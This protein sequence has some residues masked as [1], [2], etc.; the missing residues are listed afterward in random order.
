M[1]R[2]TVVAKRRFYYGGRDV[3][4]GPVEMH[5]A[6]AAAYARRGIVSL[7]R[8]VVAV[9]REPIAAPPA[10]EP[11]T[12]PAALPA[13]VDPEPTDTATPIPERRRRAY[14]RRDITAE[15]TP[16]LRAEGDSV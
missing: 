7:S 4:P 12:A 10:D 15:E 16:D 13:S 14:R 9:T 5:A 11:A 2:V 1:A 8:R 6:D 3:S